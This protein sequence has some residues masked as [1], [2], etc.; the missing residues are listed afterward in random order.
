MKE[1]ESA[2][3]VPLFWKKYHI[4]WISGTFF[5]G[6]IVVFILNYFIN[7]PSIAT[8][9][10]VRI[11]DISYTYINPLLECDSG[12]SISQGLNSFKN[13]LQSYVDELTE[14]KKA[15]FISIYFRDMNNGP[16][17]GINENAEFYPAS[18]LKV[19]IAMAYFEQFESNPG[20]LSQKIT[21]TKSI[22]QDVEYFKSSTIKLGQTYSIKDLISAMLVNSDNDALDL[23][24]TNSAANN[25]DTR[26]TFKYLNV[27]ISSDGM[28]TVA[29]Y[30]TFFRIL[31][32]ASYLDY[33][34]SE[35]LLSMLAESTFTQGLRAGVPANIPVAHK[36]GERWTYTD[37][38]KELHDCGII[39]YPNHPYL[40]CVMTKGTDLDDMAS[41]IS[42]I[43]KFVYNEVNKQLN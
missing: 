6:A 32:N 21:F 20:L 19:P 31:F 27:N 28:I 29:Q 16:W 9:A 1:I 30:S 25:V 2:K 17:F 37:P 11:N 7:L 18:L 42:G 15:D 10:D 14:S 33:D 13:S 26:D 40:L 4:V 39:Y 23:L 8:S 12:S 36:F 35:K 5:A 43:S 41:A 22:N 24:V 3:K 38:E 34:D